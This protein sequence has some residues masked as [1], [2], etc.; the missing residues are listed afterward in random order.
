MLP[1]TCS[2]LLWVDV[3]VRYYQSSGLENL[4]LV[5]IPFAGRHTG[6]ATFEMFEKLFDAICALWKNK[7]IGCLKDGA[8]N[9][10]GRLSGVVTW[11]Q[12]VVKPNFIRVWCLVHQIDIVMQKVYKNAGC[13]FHKTLTSIISFLRRQKN[14]MRKCRPSVRIYLNSTGFNVASRSISS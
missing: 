6:L 8:A 13:D 4:D 14:L 10:I 11:I 9:M 7:L 1:P 2:R 3:R 5:T 12:N